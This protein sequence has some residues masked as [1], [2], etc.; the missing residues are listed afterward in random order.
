MRLTRTGI[1]LLTAQ[2]RSVL[3]KCWLINVG[4][5]ALMAPAAVMTTAAV[6]AEPAAA[7]TKLSDYSSPLGAKSLYTVTTATAAEADLANVFAVKEYN[8]S[9]GA[10]ET[11]Y[12][13]IALKNAS[14]GTGSNVKYY[15][16]AKVANSSRI[17]LVETTS[18]DADLT[19]HYN[20][21][22]DLNV[23][24]G[25]V[26]TIFN[27]DVL[28]QEI[29]N[30]IAVAG[31]LTNLDSDFVGDTSTVTS[32]DDYHHSAVLVEATGTINN[33]NS[34]FVGN[35][36]SATDKE[37]DGGLIKAMGK[38]GTANVEMV[39]NT[40]DSNADVQGGLIYVSNAGEITN[41]NGQFISN[42]ASIGGTLL[43]GVIHNAGTMG[44]GTIKWY[45]V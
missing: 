43:G 42:G 35:K 26:Q 1:G 37:V 14:M 27:T 44:T 25:T 2:Y 33:I 16:W 22:A 3:K 32:S 21:V 15:K 17:Q 24:Y 45:C 6:T 18:S 11:H 7:A 40:V 36:I 30:K 39:S 19:V 29:K 41:L 4:L 20:T 13:K 8:A 10:T 38:I 31:T 34:S 9:T 12:Y 5:Y 28:G 23:A